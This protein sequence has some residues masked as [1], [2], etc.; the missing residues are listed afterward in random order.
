M[1]MFEMNGFDV[2]A[3][4]KNDPQTMDILF[5]VLSVAQDKARGFKIELTEIQSLDT[6]ILFNERQFA[7]TRQSKKKA[8]ILD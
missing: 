8:M 1:M 5:I 4:L 3:I 6:G 7:G 2:A